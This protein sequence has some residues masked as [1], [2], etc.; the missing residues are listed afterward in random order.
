[1]VVEGDGEQVVAHVGLRA[2]GSLAD[3][4]GLGAA[5]S[6]WVP[7]PRLGFHDRGKVLMQATLMLARWW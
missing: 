7:Q 6:V 4:L 1:V 3:R 5:L 2:V